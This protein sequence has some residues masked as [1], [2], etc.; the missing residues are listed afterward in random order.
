MNYKAQIY[1]PEMPNLLSG[2]HSIDWILTESTSNSTTITI[3]TKKKI[4]QINKNK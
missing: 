2:I 4:K 3:I 1:R